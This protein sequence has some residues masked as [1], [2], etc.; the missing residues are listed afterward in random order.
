MITVCE[1]CQRGLSGQRAVMCA[2]CGA[3]YHG[4]CWDYLG[5]CQCENENGHQQVPHTGIAL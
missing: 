4:R 1:H 3:E 2:S 5:G